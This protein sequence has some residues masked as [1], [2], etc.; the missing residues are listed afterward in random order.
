MDRVLRRSNLRLVLS[1]DLCIAALKSRAVIAVGGDD[2]RDWLQGLITQDVETLRAGELRFGALLSPQGRLLFDLFVLGSEQGCLL[3]APAEGRA[4]LM[5]RLKL[6]RLRARVTLELDETPVQAAWGADPGAGFTLDP[7]LPQLGWRGYGVAAASN[8]DEAAY[9][10][11][12]LKLGVP[13]TADFGADT[14]YPIEADFDLLNGV[15]FK[16]GCFVGQETTSRMKR[17]GGIRS[18]MAPI[19]FDGPPLS[20]GAE[21]LRGQLRAGEVLSGMEG[22]AT[23][24]LRLDRAHGPLNCEGRPVKVEWPAWMGPPA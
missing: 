18:R 8:R 14:T 6:Y 10:V 19:V 11:H 7:R 2:W 3:D 20:P 21:I 1:P 9:D 23:A 5:G 16:K 22:R 15:D 13:G 12:R 4:A 24:L 17:R